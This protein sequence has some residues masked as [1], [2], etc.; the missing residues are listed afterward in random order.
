MLQAVLNKGK[1]SHAFSGAKFKPIEDT[2]TSSVIGIMQYLPDTLFWHLLKSAC[3]RSNKTLPETIG[4]VKE[5]HFWDRF[6]AGETTNAKQV[7]PDVWV[8]TE[9]YD[10][11][12]E[13]KRSDYS[14]ENS[15]KEQQWK[16]QIIALQGSYGD[17][18]PR[19]LI[20][21]AIGGND[22]LKD[23]ILHINNKEFVIHT[24]SWYNLLDC[25]LEELKYSTAESC[26]AYIRRALQD[27]IRAMTLH[28]FIKTVWLDTLLQIKTKE[29]SDMVLFDLWEFDNKPQMV[30][31]QSFTITN[32]TDLS[33][34]WTLAK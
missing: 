25:V 13:A 32:E 2:L 22:S 23:S 17:E 28:R 4:N 8:E 6:D 18:K 33:K 26:P 12:I 7:E 34:I 29:G 1:Y 11:I 15:Q 14:A 19:P 20:Y 9:I 5:F 3:G 16:D 27:I 24:A 10:I 21:I 30:S 31:I